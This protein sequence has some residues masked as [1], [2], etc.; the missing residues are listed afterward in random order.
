MDRLFFECG[1]RAALLVVGTAIVLYAMRVKAASARHSIWAGVL[2]C[3][4]VLPIWTAWGPKASLRVLSPLSQSTAIRALALTDFPSPGALRR[5]PVSPR[6]A[7]FLSVYLLGSCL[8]LVRLAIG[9]VRARR[10]LR[11]AVLRD[12]V[13]TSFL[14]AAPVTVGLF[15]PTVI[16]PEHWRE[17]SQT[18]LDAILTHE[19]EHAR[20]RHSLVQWLA[21][22]NRA[23]F[24]LHPIAWWLERHLSALAE[25]SCDNAVLLCGHDPREYSEYLIDMARSVNRSG[26]R[27]NIAGMAMPGSS[28]PR[29]IRL[30]LDSGSVPQVSR[31]RMASVCVACAISCT[32]FAAG[33]LDHAETKTSSAGH[34]E[35]T[36]AAHP[37]SEFVLGEVKIEGEIHDREGVANRILQAWK[38]REY[39]D[40]KKLIDEVA[41]G[42]RG[43]FQER[44]YFKVVVH[45]PTSRPLGEVADGKQRILIV[46]AVTEGDQFRLGNLKIQGV[47][48]DHALSI[49]VET[50]REQFHTKSGDLFNMT[51]M[52]EGLERLNRMYGN[53]GYA[54]ARVEP[55]TEVDVRSRRIDLILRIAEGPRTP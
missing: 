19:S 31:M 24:W 41:A 11:N 44:G 25:E 6:F 2:A 16:F 18:Q 10:L 47:P 15:H 9:T 34:T 5:A 55:D 42:I 50:L 1:I 37:T 53:H 36:F 51:D 21:L 14:C 4:L 38:S 7:V 54:D 32:A 35:I 28:L 17:W 27:L 26:G 20:R 12:G 22:F 30:I 29:R 8:L 45:D 13:R 39:E 40:D 48:P 49:P 52:R 33:N 46:A 43:D 3:M 23:L